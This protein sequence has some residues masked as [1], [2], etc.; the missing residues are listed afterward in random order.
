[1]Q[2]REL[3]SLLLLLVPPRVVFGGL[4][5][6]ARGSIEIRD[7]SVEIAGIEVEVGGSGL[8]L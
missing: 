2:L 1:M 6:A 4:W 3:A 8:V 5:W 7:Y